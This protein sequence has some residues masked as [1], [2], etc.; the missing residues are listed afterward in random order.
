M[1][2]SQRKQQLAAVA[3]CGDQNAA[4]ELFKNNGAAIT[5]T[6]LE[7]IGKYLQAAKDS[8]GEIPDELAEKVAGGSIDLANVLT[9]IGG[10]IAALGPMI[11]QIIN[12]FNPQTTPTDG[13]A[14][15]QASGANTNSDGTGTDTNSGE[16][17]AK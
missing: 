5:S 7:N 14:T 3:A 11:Q 10:I 9:T 13:G 8:D 17:T 6:E 12:L 4:L 1:R 15:T 2:T 16:Q